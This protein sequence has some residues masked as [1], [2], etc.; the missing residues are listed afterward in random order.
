MNLKTHPNMVRKAA[1]LLPTEA[2]LQRII[3]TYDI[4]EA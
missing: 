4:P 3:D 2:E 1:G